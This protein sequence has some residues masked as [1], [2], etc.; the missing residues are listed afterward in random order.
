MPC[1]NSA[2]SCQITRHEIISPYYRAAFDGLGDGTIQ[3]LVAQAATHLNWCWYRFLPAKEHS[4]HEHRKPL[5]H[6]YPQ[7]W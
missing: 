3:F 1:W 4:H 7:G 2:R 6:S 5:C